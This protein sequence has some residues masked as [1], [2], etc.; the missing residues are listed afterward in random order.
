[1]SARISALPVSNTFT[2]PSKRVALRARRI[3]LSSDATLKPKFLF[4]TMIK[5][6]IFSFLP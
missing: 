5:A 6:E 2:F 3:N 1:L 4:F